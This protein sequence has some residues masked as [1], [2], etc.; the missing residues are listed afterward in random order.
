VIRRAA[1]PPSRGVVGV[2]W[3][4]RV[5]AGWRE[6]AVERKAMATPDGDAELLAQAL[7]GYLDSAP[8]HHPTRQ[9]GMPLERL[10]QGRDDLVERV[11][12]TF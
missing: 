4:V 6:G 11:T 7:L 12:R 9:C 5:R 8:F 3:R 10:E 1:D 2:W